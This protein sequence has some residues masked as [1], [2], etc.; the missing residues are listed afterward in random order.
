M[1]Y[2]TAK[3]VAERLGV[4]INT[5]WRWV[6]EQDDFPKPKKLGEKTTRWRLEDVDNWANDRER[7]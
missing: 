7:V 1:A 2:L 5:V 3:Q 6:R 4:S